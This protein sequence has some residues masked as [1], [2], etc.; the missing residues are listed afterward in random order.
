[1]A[2][3]P[4]LK[5]M[6]S[7]CTETR[8]AG[9][10]STG[11]TPLGTLRAPSHCGPLV[12]HPCGVGHVPGPACTAPVTPA[13][14]PAGAAAAA[15]ASPPPPVHPPRISVGFTARQPAIHPQA[16]PAAVEAAAAAAAAAAAG[17]PRSA[18]VPEGPAMTMLASPQGGWLTYMCSCTPGLRASLRVA[19]LK[20]KMD[21]LRLCLP[22]L[23]AAGTGAAAG[24]AA[25]AGATAAS[26]AAS[27]P[28]SLVCGGGPAAAVTVCGACC[29]VAA[30]SCASPPSCVPS[31]P[32]AALACGF[33]AS[34]VWCETARRA[35]SCTQ[36]SSARLA[37]TSAWLSFRTAPSV[38]R[39]L[40]PRHFVPVPRAT[41]HGPDGSAP[42]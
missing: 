38:L 37:T 41:T 2:L 40:A 1:M 19:G 22:C 18:G 27:D 15:A 14:H 10:A 17:P 3:A 4:V 23:A 5:W 39:L 21:C 35:S 11:P 30:S 32:G 12:Q 28:A 20:M 24:A 25:S 31:A 9:G 26:G 29:C 7:G 6:K 34:S 36:A 33:E 8:V 16:P 13:A 42:G